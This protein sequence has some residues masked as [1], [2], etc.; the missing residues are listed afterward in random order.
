LKPNPDQSK[1]EGHVVC[2]DLAAHASVRA[3][4][5]QLAEWRRQPGPPPSEPLPL[6]LLRHADEQTVAGVAAILHAIHQNLPGARFAEWAVL[7]APCF[8]GRA[9]LANALQRFRAEGAWG[10]SP[11]LAAH[12]S[13]HSLAGTVSLALKIQGPNYGVGGGPGSAGEALLAAAALLERRTQP[14]VWVVLTGWQTEPVPEPTG[15]VPRG[16][17]CAALALALV[18]PR[19]PG[20]G[21]RLRVTARDGRDADSRQASAAPFDLFRLEALLANAVGSAG[22]LV[23]DFDAGGRVEV[24]WMGPGRTGTPSEREFRPNEAVARGASWV[25]AETKR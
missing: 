22:P 17:I 9:V 4:V 21:I 16:S 1:S 24:E 13:L 19:I 11:H 15:Q 20:Q 5:D 23:Q 3:T 10:I 14:G 18:P 7:G 25:G 8:L 6:A 12:R 2:C